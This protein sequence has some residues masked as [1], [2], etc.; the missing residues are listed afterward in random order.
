M[1]QQAAFDASWMHLGPKPLLDQARQFRRPHGWL[2]LAC[3]DEE[4]QDLVGQF[5]RLRRAPF[6]GHQAGDPMFLEGFQRL[7]EGGPGETESRR[8]ASYRMA[9]ALHAAQHLVL[10]LDQISGIEEAALDKQGIGD[11]ARPWI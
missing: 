10:D 3:F 6:V 5:V 8:G 4:G 2:L 7:I 11:R 9:L 1:A